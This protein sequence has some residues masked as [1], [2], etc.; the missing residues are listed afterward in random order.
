[1]NEFDLDLE[2]ADIA[3]IDARLKR[4][5]QEL[6]VKATRAGLRAAGKPVVNRVKDAAPVDDGDLSQ[7]INLKLLGKKKTAKL[8]PLVAR[9]QRSI[10]N[11][12]GVVMIIGPNK[13]VDGK[14]QGFKGALMEFGSSAGE[15]V[16]KRGHMKGH[17]YISKGV[18][19]QPFLEP[20]FDAEKAGINRRFYK[21]MTRYLNRID[22][23]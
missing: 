3:A 23:A 13:K 11:N 4:L 15:R 22:R 9:N 12:P 6:Q 20:S 1:V 19:A 17:R 7:S 8:R 18:Q 16:G 2:P 14:H 5:S 10:I 21:G